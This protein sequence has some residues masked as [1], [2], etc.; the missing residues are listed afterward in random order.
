MLRYCLLVLPL[1]L[2]ACSSNPE[3]ADS[4]AAIIASRL[5]ETSWRLQHI[6][7]MNDETFVPATG[8]VFT[9]HFQAEDRVAMQADCNRGSGSYNQTGSQLE[10]GVIATTRALCPPASLHDRFLS[11]LEY[12]R[13]FVL[14]DGKLH[15]ATMADGA[16]L[17]FV[18][19]LESEL[20]QNGTAVIRPTFDCSSASGTVEQ[21]ICTD[22]DLALL[23]QQLNYFYTTA[24]QR[25][26]AEER[27]VFRA[28]QRG[29]I[30][31]RN[32]CWQAEDAAACVRE[33]SE[34]R[35]SELQI[36]S[37]SVRVPEA[38]LYSCPP[39][40]ELEN[41]YYNNTVLPMLVLNDGTEQA[42]MHRLPSAS[43]ARYGIGNLQF[44]D[45]G[46]E[47]LFIESE[48]QVQCVTQ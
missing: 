15:L 13:S 35:I 21:L 11:N 4:P 38:V 42:V 23:D 31:G 48:D 29:W 36:S 25:M 22:S 2:A 24:L 47:A 3:S 19:I 40:K 27:E 34:R 43:G 12:V 16:I 5:A 9:L 28:L 10:F 7:S 32:D 37:G 18:P 46:D 1:L 44:W 30:S 45:R 41:Y 14:Q 20:A 8:A 17:T 26:A 33:E 6:Q 39:D